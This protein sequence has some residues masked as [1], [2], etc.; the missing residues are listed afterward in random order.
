MSAIETRRY[1]NNEFT[2][3]QK[4]RAAVG[5]DDE[6]NNAGEYINRAYEA[7]N[8]LNIKAQA[9]ADN[10]ARGGCEQCHKKCKHERSEKCDPCDSLT[11][12]CVP[13]PH[14]VVYC[15]ED[16]IITKHDFKK[17]AVNGLIINKPGYYCLGGNIKFNPTVRATTAITIAAS[18]VVFDFNKY[19]IKQCN[20][21]CDIYGVAIARCVSR[22]KITG[23]QGVSKITNFTATGIRVL[24]N[25]QH[26]TVENVITTHDKAV[27][28]RNVDIPKSANDI[29]DTRI[30]CGIVVG[31]GNTAGLIFK[32]TDQ[33]NLVEDFTLKNVVCE[34]SVIGCHIVFTKVALLE[35]SLFTLNSYYGLLC[36]PNW[37]VPSLID[38]TVQCFPV[39]QNIVARR[40]RGDFN[41]GPF[42]ELT[43]PAETFNYDFLSG[44]AFYNALDCLVEDSTANDN[45]SPTH[46]I[47]I[48]HD[49]SQGMFWNGAQASNNKSTGF[50]AFGFHMRGSL[51]FRSGLPYGLYRPLD[52]N[53]SATIRNVVAANNSSP[54]KS[55]GISFCCSDSVSV[56]NC[57]AQGQKSDGG[58]A[59][60]F[61]VAGTIGTIGIIGSDSNN[62]NFK[63]CVA[64]G[65]GNIKAVSTVGFYIGTNDARVVIDNCVANGNCNG[66][67]ISAG[68]LVNAPNGLLF[69]GTFGVSRLVISNSTIHANGT[70]SVNLSGGIVVYNNQKADDLP[71]DYLLIDQNII[72]HN[73]GDGIR[74][75]GNIER[76]VIK[77][78]EIIDNTDVGIN[79]LTT[80]STNTIVIKNIAVTND[81]GNYVGV[82]NEAIIFVVYPQLGVECDNLRNWSVVTQ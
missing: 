57:T 32:G 22:V 54:I 11:P 58:Q 52:K 5:L 4:L 47:A 13:S 61:E 38:S 43:N 66:T 26:I 37:F 69:K 31:E 18:G 71:I 63:N 2:R 36:G 44:L 15:G 45:L 70:E 34:K 10:S 72:S 42:E 51:P 24:G 12:I 40:L 30:T 21:M 23:E 19:S 75:D 49:G 68:I 73:F 50:D 79:L 48:D 33:R 74:S 14:A 56:E 82:S 60:G 7:Q 39:V 6:I 64:Q 35:D 59:H 65:N 62:I 46:L 78:N 17:D 29:I 25:T 27:G 81:G 67:N 1:P 16:N 53:S 20:D 28:L 77:R 9:Q 80:G 3:A 8:A 41:N 76:F 55:V